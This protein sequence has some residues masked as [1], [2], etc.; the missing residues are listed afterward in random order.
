MEQFP[1]VEPLQPHNLTMPRISND[2][3]KQFIALKTS[4]EAERSKLVARLAELDRALG[5]LAAP[6]APVAADA[7]A[8][9][10][11]GKPGRPAGKVSKKR[12]KN[13]LSLKEAVLKVLGTSALKKEQILA[14]V[15]KLG[16][17][18][19]AGKP[20]NSLNTLLYGSK[21]PKFKNADGAFSVAK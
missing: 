21:N 10:V 2:P 1:S 6:S 17:K 12:A 7:P 4:M 8:P 13:E 11:A 5:V 20:I 18:F 3:L 14:G 15:T 9:K 19:S 16:Y